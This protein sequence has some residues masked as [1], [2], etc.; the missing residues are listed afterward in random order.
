MGHIAGSVATVLSGVLGCLWLG[1]IM[2]GTWHTK[3]ITGIM[4]Y[5]VG[6]FQVTTKHGAL[7]WIGSKL[8]K[9]IGD[10]L[11][12]ISDGTSW[13][14]ESRNTWCS[15]PDSF[16]LARVI[17]DSACDTWGWMY[18]A[19]MTMGVMGIFAVIF[20]FLASGFGHYYW[21]VEARAEP[22]MWAR[23][24]FTLAPS[25]ALLALCLY[26]G[27][28]WNFSDWNPNP[29]VSNHPS[30]TYGFTF[31]WVLAVVSWIPLVLHEVFAGKAWVEDHN[32]AAAEYRHEQREAAMMGADYGGYNYGAM[33]PPMGG[34]V[35]PPMQQQGNY[36]GGG[37]FGIQG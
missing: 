37:D 19:G 21:H 14:S 8:D 16:G 7:A 31:A 9:G 27:M 32:E 3:V 34:P 12:S 11:K 22:R 24:G 25:T 2:F 17:T 23:W 5:N 33:G 26:T 1:T 28:T 36:G 29:T 10:F 18:V 15:V 6:I 4:S 35:G 20:F 13:I 30:H